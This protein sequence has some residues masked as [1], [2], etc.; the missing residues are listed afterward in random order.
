MCIARLS[1]TV[2]YTS[3]RASLAGR[4][5]VYTGAATQAEGIIHSPRG[6][7]RYAGGIPEFWNI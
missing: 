2:Y 4:S 7:H 3:D 5:A 1:I 6:D